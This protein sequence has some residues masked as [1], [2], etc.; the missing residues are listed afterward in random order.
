MILKSLHFVIKYCLTYDVHTFCKI[1]IDN[2]KVISL[3]SKVYGNNALIIN[4]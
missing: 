1:T 3:I 4:N 2:W